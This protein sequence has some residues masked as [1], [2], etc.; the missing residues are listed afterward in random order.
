ML[1]KD[2]LSSIAGWAQHGAELAQ[3]SLREIH[4]ADSGLEIR[5]IQ[6][7]TLAELP[8]CVPCFEGECVAGV[9]N[10]FE[11]GL[12]GTALLA[13]DPKDALAWVRSKPGDDDLLESFVRLGGT[14]QSSVVCEIGKG[15]GLAMRAESAELNENSVPLIL[16]GTHA[17]SDTAVVAVS[18]LVAA[19]DEVLPVQ[20]YLMIEPKLLCTALAA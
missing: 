10:R 15:L 16:F 4:T 17:P 11:G 5:N 2:Q 12:C 14:V 1:T 19:G 18:L 6:C 13:M 8:D 3:A 9:V 20:I 7:A